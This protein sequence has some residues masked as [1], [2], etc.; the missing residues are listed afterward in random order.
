MSRKPEPVPIRN[1][2]ALADYTTLKLGGNAKLFAECRS[3]TELVAA[4]EYARK[5]HVRT[6]VLGGGSNTIFHDEGFD[7]LVIKIAMHGVQFIRE[8]G[9]VRMVVAA[10]ETWDDFVNLCVSHGLAGIECL[11]GIPGLV[12]ATPIQNV[13]AYGQEVSETIESVKAIQRDT[14]HQ[15]TFAHQDCMFAYRRSRFNH[16]DLDA[17]VI[18]EVTFRL[19]ADKEPEVRYAELQKYIDV[20]MNLSGLSA[21]QPKLEAVRNAVLALRK[22]KSMVIDA[23]DLHSRSVGSFFKNPLLNKNEFSDFQQRCV[24]AGIEES[25]PS[26]PA[27]GRVKVAAAWLVENAGYRKGFRSGGV[28]VSANHSLALVNYGGTTFELLAL[29]E[30]IQLKVEE[31]FGILLER[32]PVIVSV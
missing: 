10:G 7:G 20:N 3:Q 1:N 19:Q 13:G 16:G 31:M 14:L 29:A 4:L 23:A 15:R 26:F 2:V 21:G 18:T 12:G 28:G 17:F 8:E 24:A 5:H 25:A 30:E 22:T 11:S 9:V 32:E 6:H 27:G